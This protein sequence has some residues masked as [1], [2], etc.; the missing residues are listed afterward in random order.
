MIIIYYYI[1]MFF[2]S[3]SRQVI[4]TNLLILQWAL[5]AVSLLA[6]LSATTLTIL[7]SKAVRNNKHTNMEKVIISIIRW[8]IFALCKLIN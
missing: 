1:K 3:P 5:M 4:P 6:L 8:R 2:K 7:V